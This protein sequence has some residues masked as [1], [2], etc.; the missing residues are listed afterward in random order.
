M[1]GVFKFDIFDQKNTSIICEY[2][3]NILTGLV[4]WYVTYFRDRICLILHYIYRR[5][6]NNSKC[7]SG[8][9]NQLQLVVRWPM[10]R[11]SFHINPTKY[12]EHDHPQESPPPR[13]ST[14]LWSISQTS[15]YFE[16]CLP[17]RE[18][19]GGPCNV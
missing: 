11:W 18:G 7:L 3:V 10:L 2:F 12:V 16:P 9:E 8:T 5:G 4:L 14:D 6:R 15:G 19:S 13:S 17:L 1:A